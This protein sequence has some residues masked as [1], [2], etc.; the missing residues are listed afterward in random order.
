MIDTR[1]Y[2]H[3]SIHKM[4]EEFHRIYRKLVSELYKNSD[5]N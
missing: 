3:K 2:F 1:D 5:K 4:S